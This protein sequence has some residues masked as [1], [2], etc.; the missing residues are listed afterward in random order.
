LKNGAGGG[1]EDDGDG[2][3]TGFLNHQNLKTFSMH[4]LDEKLVPRF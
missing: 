4:N 3:A 1:E 2:R